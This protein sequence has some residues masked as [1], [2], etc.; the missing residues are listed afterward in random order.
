MIPIVLNI[1]NFFNF[2]I[3][4]IFLNLPPPETLAS[5]ASSENQSNLTKAMI[6]DI[7]GI[8][9]DLESKRWMEFR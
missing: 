6:V 2:L 7:Q 8:T 4:L 5:P 1:F 9:K 3:F